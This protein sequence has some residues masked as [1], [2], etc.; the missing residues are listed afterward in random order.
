MVV[1]VV[2]S[3]LVPV[4]V[5]VDANVEVGEAVLV[6]VR[7]EV[8]VADAVDVGLEV[9]V[10]VGVA[11][12]VPVGVLVGLV[13]A[14]AL[15]L[16]VAVAVTLVVA[17]VVCVVRS[18]LANDPSWKPSKASFRAFAVFW[19]SASLAVFTYRYLYTEH[20]RVG[21]W[22]VPGPVISATMELSARAVC[23][24]LLFSFCCAA[25]VS[26]AVPSTISQLSASVLEF[27]H[28]CRAL[29]SVEAC[30]W[31]C[32]SWTYA[33]WYRSPTAL[34]LVRP[35]EPVVTDVDAVDVTEDV[36]EDVRDVAAD[37]VALLEPVEVADEVGEAVTVAVGVDVAVVVPEA[38]PDEV[39]VV[40][41][42]VV[43][44]VVGDV[45]GHV[46]HIT[47]QYVFTST[48]PPNCFV[49]QNGLSRDRHFGGSSLPLHS[50][51]VVVG[52]VVWLVVALAVGV[53]V[54]VLVG[55]AVAEDVAVVVVVTVVVVVVAV[56]VGCVVVVMVAASTGLEKCRT[57]RSNGYAA[58]SAAAVT[59]TSPW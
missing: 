5:C 19:H 6:L 55:V 38:V 18:Q 3:E 29:V 46:E 40:V 7:V 37:L 41:A 36:C 8:G 13:V 58:G 45:V 17:V 15:R 50:P 10:V 23:R 49:P 25:V 52:V 47:G 59:L 48:C 43:M 39:R 54:G 20:R 22:G 35:K 34:Q 30:C 2:V 1:M 33:S 12:L 26:K 53:A 11:V 27:E 4:E 31:Q 32:A 28:C 56:V 42:V 9:R 57:Y 44:D 24:H 21:T 16:V 51:S 14:D